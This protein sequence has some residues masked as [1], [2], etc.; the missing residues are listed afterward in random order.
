ME[1]T[2][3]VA[4]SRFINLEIWYKHF[5]TPCIA[6]P[7][8]VFTFRLFRYNYQKDFFIFQ[9]TNKLIEIAD[10]EIGKHSYFTIFNSTVQYLSRI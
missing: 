8:S 3:L 9:N 4:K 7:T 10:A 6:L 2:Y 5:E 1:V